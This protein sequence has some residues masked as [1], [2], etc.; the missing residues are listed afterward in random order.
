MSGDFCP[1]CLSDFDPRGM[2]E[3]KDYAGNFTARCNTCN[4]HIEVNVRTVPEFE[5][6]KG[7]C[8]LCRDVLAE[9]DK[10]YCPPCQ[11]RLQ[12]LSDYN[13]RADVQA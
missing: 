3:S 8:P 12:E 6:S 2:W 1:H 9:S 10:H 4:R 7:R 5:L 13:K 11:A